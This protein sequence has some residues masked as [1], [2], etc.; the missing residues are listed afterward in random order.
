MASTTTSAV[1]RL[2]PSGAKSLL[3]GV[4]YVMLDIDGVIWAGDHVIDGIPETLRWLQDDMGISVRF[5]TNNSTKTRMDT[6]DKFHGKGM[7]WV[8]EDLVMTSAYASTVQLLKHGD[9][10][11]D[12][13]DITDNDDEEN[14]SKCGGK[15][16]SRRV[17]DRN[18][19][20]LGDKGLHTEVRRGL[21]PSKTTYGYEMVHPSLLP[22]LVPH[23]HSNNKETEN[24]TEKEKM[25]AS[26]FTNF[27]YSPAVVLNS[28]DHPVVPIG[29]IR[30]NNN[31]TTTTMAG[32]G[33]ERA[34]LGDVQELV[35]LSDLNVGAIISGLDPN[36]NYHKVATA[37]LI[38]Q[39]HNA[40]QKNKQNTDTQ[41][42]GLCANVEGSIPWIQTNP[43]QELPMQHVTS[44]ISNDA[45]N[46]SSSSSHMFFLP[47]A[48]TT[49]GLMTRYLCR[50]PDK[51]CGK[52]HPDMAFALF[53]K[54]LAEKKE[55]LQSSANGGGGYCAPID[56]ASEVLMVGDRVSTDIVFGRRA[57]CK[58]MLVLSGC[59]N[60]SHVE[61]APE[62]DRPDYVAASLSQLRELYQ[63]Q[64]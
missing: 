33:C 45:N 1:R 38:L 48:G 27:P 18:V 51:V 52:P 24:T 9:A 39:V 61:G 37:G 23:I 59:E 55:E 58:T 50:G 5:M 53:D 11:G 29:G 2:T 56:P 22:H 30:P 3:S 12:T 34:E 8:H 31:T 46:S 43:D 57:G 19:F 28:L 60:E 35:K 15:K 62:E 32:G 54:L 25:L 20:V 49:E 16:R 6:V 40:K 26:S 36:L 44:S 14:S 21:H 13:I 4:K 7:T 42:D 63:S 47:G 10:T 64:E 17:Y 41:K